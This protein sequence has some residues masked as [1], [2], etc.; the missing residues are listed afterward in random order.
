VVGNILARID[1]LG[2]TTNYTY[3]A[4]DRRT[5]ITDALGNGTY[6]TYDATGNRTQ[7]EDALGQTTKYV[8]DGLNRQ[9]KVIDAKNNP[10]RTAYDAVGNIRSITDSV[11]NTTSYTYDAL[12]R[13][14]TDTNSLGK[15]RTYGYDAVGD[16]IQT[17]D[18]DGR[19]RTYNYDALYRQTAEHWLD[20][21][22]NDIRTFNYG[23]DAVGHLLT[24][25]DPDSKY[26][27]TYDL[28]DRITSIDNLGTTGVPNVLLTYSYDAAGNL[29]SVTDKI[30]GILKGTNAYTYDI[31]NRATRITQSGTGVQGKRVDM[32]YDAVNQMTG[33]NRY[34]DL[35]G[36]LSVANSIYTYDTVGR[37]TNLEYKRGTSTL[38]SYGLVYDAA[39]RITQSA[40][41]DGVQDYRYDNTNQLTR[42]THTTQA[43]ESYDYDANGNRT[44]AGTGTNKQLLTDGVYDYTYDDEGNR[45][46]RTEISTGKI[47]EYVWDYRNRLSSVVFKDAAGNVV[48]SIAYTYDVNDRRISKKIDGVV[49]ERYV[50][51]GANIALVFDGAGVQT[52]RY[53]YSTGVDQILADE[54]GG[55]VVWA[56]ADNL[57]T[58]RDVVDGGGVVLNHVTF[59]SYGR[60]IAQTNPAVDFRYGFTG[61]EQDSE[62][63]LDYYRARY[64]DSNVGR[65]ISEDPIGFNAGDA[66]LYRYV[67]NSPTNFIDPSGNVG[68][69]INQL[70]GVDPNC[71]AQKP[72]ED[73]CKDSLID[74]K[75]FNKYIKDIEKYKNDWKNAKTPKARA[76]FFKKIINEANKQAGLPDV[77]IVFESFGNRDSGAYDVRDNTIHLNDDI[78]NSTKELEFYR[79]AGLAYHESRHMEQYYRAIQSDGQ[80]GT[81]NFANL[82]GAKLNFITTALSSTLPNSRREFAN[83][84][85]ALHTQRLTPG[86]KYSAIPPKNGADSPE[87]KIY[88]NV[89]VEWDTYAINRVMFNRFLKGKPSYSN[90]YRVG[91]NAADAGIKNG[92]DR[93]DCLTK[94]G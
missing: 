45:T 63:G 31:L 8:F 26:S 84:M 86:N 13:Q 64:Y 54:R 77:D 42:A 36:T 71:L 18:R 17:I 27:Y 15:T 90:Y 87:D 72:K 33:L 66:N 94:P 35:A 2:E 32:T 74:P 82:V 4:L 16:L 93:Y 5:A 61:R 39:N 76:D 24:T 38:A 34:G 65:F 83:T 89:P 69:N 68:N 1:E 73:P 67:G 10:T 9:I 11:G 40:G 48:K 43:D 78:F 30:N 92:Y 19:K 57:G 79:V 55:S 75:I 20:S 22:G 44:N 23:Y 46:K 7:V 59:D 29:L 51:D 52:H 53:L 85:R 88:P 25:T 3:D 21:L 70:N 37:L 47:T 56:L 41:T 60:V 81:S 6:Y 62:T 12:D 28:V 80:N 14:I 58:V 91:N 50:Y 49:A